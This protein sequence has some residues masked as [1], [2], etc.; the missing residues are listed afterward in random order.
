MTT[1]TWM[2]DRPQPNKSVRM[3]EVCGSIEPRRKSIAHNARLAVRRG[4]GTLA[5][6]DKSKSLVYFSNGRAPPLAA[7][8]LCA[9]R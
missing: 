1:P 9:V 7:N 6:S 5:A 8:R 2:S 4:K 3:D